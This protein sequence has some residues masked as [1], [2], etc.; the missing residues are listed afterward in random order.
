[1]L[2]TQGLYYTCGDSDECKLK[3]GDIGRT[4]Q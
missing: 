1:M 3:E 2:N 4:V